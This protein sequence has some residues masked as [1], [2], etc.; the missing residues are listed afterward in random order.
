MAWN[1]ARNVSREDLTGPVG[2]VG[3]KMMR[4]D[5]RIKTIT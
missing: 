1:V 5:L 4:S 3:R 2:V